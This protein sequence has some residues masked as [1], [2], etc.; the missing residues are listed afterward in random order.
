MVKWGWILGATAAVLLIGCSSDPPRKKRILDDPTEFGET[1]EAEPET[2]SAEDHVDTAMIYYHGGKLKEAESQFQMALKQEPEMPDAH[3]GL[4]YVLHFEAF[5]Q[6]QAQ[7][8]REAIDLHQKS[9]GHFLEALK[10]N[11]KKVE[12]LVG[13]AMVNFDEYYYFVPHKQEYRVRATGYLDRARATAPNNPGVQANCNFQDAK[14]CLSEK[15]YAE[16]KRLLEDVV[17]SPGLDP[18]SQV[19]AHYMLAG[20]Y[21]MLNDKERAIEQYRIYLQKYPNASDAQDVNDIIVK[22]QETMATPHEDGGEGH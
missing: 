22:L 19:Q 7:K 6:I 3:C 18:M 20:C 8:P 15:G 4:G 12:A 11:P 21:V 17:D 13:L 14:F 5:M 1:I 10:K 2:F 16:A 9:A